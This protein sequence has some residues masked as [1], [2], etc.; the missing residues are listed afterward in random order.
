MSDP[1]H[2]AV[3]AAELA[4]FDGTDLEATESFYGIEGALH[5]VVDG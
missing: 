5:S 4:A 1:D 2:T 3:Y